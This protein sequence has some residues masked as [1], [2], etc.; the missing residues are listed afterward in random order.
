MGNFRNEILDLDYDITFDMVRDCAVRQLS[1]GKM[2]KAKLFAAFESAGIIDCLLGEPEEIEIYDWGCGQG[3]ATI[4]L[5][6]YINEKGF[7]PKILR[8][9]LID[10]SEKALERAKFILSQYDL[11]YNVEIKL[12]AKKFDDLIVDDIEDIDGNEIRKI[13]LF[14]NILD[15]TTFDLADFTHLFQKSFLIFIIN[16]AAFV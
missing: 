4:C 2:H 10:P 3:T 15:V 16:K 13:H 5:L 7:S 8:V 14:S 12:T 9:N 11:L 1:V 6:D